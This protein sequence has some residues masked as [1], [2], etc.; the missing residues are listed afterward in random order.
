MIISVNWLKKF[1]DFDMPID[2]LAT[3]I[4][5][6]LVEIESV[7]SL[8]EK[9]K[10]ALVVKVVRAERMV[11]SD[12]LSVVTIDDAQVTNGVERDNQGYVQVVCGAPNI[13]TGQTV[14]WLPPKSIVPNT[15]ATD[16]QFILDVRK[17]R[18]VTSNGMIASA[19]ELDLFDEHE[20]ILVIDDDIKAG[21]LLRDVCELDDYLLDIE[22][23]S[24]THRPDCF[25]IIGFAREV[26]AITGQEFH[27]PDWLAKT[28]PDF[29]GLKSDE[30][31]KIQATIDDPELA[32]RYQAVVVSNADGKRQSPLL[33]QTYL[34][35][36]GLRPINGIVDVTN[37]LMMLTGQPL[38]AFDYDKLVEVGG[39]AD[40]HVR[41][42]HEGEK[43]TL[44]DGKTIT[45][46]EK[47][48]VIAAGDV[49]VGL[50]GAMGGLSTAIDENTR[51]IVIESATF[52]L[53]NLRGTQMRH[54][55]FSE[56]ITRFTKGQSPALT[57]PV[58]ADAVKLMSNWT[59]AQLTSDI[60]EAYPNK[61]NAS[62]INAS[63]AA[64][65]DVLGSN[66]PKDEI[67]KI[68]RNTEF[69]VRAD[70][71]NLVVTAPWWRQDIHIFEDIVEEIGRING[72]DNIKPTL[73]L[74]KFIATRP[75]GFDDFR[76]RIRK[77]MT[78][79][80]ANEVLTYS[81]IHGD[82]LAKVGQ[83]AENSYRIVNSISPSLQYYRQSLTPSLL[84]IVHS[85]IKFGF[86]KFALFEI[87]K[88]HLKSDG[89][90]SESV[91]LESDSM[92]MVVASKMMLKGAPFY[93][94]KKI[95][96]YL[97]Q[98]LGVKLAF[99]PID[100]SLDI[101]AVMVS[102]F[103]HR[104]SAALIDIQ[105]NNVI[106][107]LGEYKRSVAKSFKLPD[108]TAGFEISTRKLYDMV[109]KSETNYQP[110]SRFPSADR[111]ICFRVA[112]SVQYDD[113]INALEKTKDSDSISMSF[114]P[115]DIYRPKDGQTKNVTIRV[116]LTSYDHTLGGNE[117][118]AEINE[119]M[120][121]VSEVTGAEVI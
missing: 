100:K 9:Y 82:L 86:D 5:A 119:L 106:G 26:A 103:E 41:A 92:A 30:T 10:D 98:E 76:A 61:F 117:V 64:I 75:S 11:D 22:N 59:G 111:D 97:T 16:D 54:G 121:R 56:A 47:D 17:L 4:G 14:V 114:M 72:F 21:T 36:V 53:Y 19:R 78:R 110:L 93:Q 102:P 2:D 27:T 113:I 109:C 3:L 45:M 60:A 99:K 7:T 25:G 69:D 84:D 89:Y 85:N 74:R 43:L 20:G 34:A 39:S 88:V 87:N 32:A 15:F 83:E 8:G 1:V 101:D 91:P 55:I 115:V 81:F 107:V 63:V 96:E 31:F 33:I 49:A 52:N 77:I 13:K 29:S 24:L 12:H 62:E 112:D 79:S 35:R 6:R 90:N 70:N 105:T 23:K 42:A 66:L 38:H 80:G 95:L 104:R 116:T 28:Q 57:A 68:L 120:Q 44:L 67:V 50:A 118:S 48:I 73:P 65:N 58:L 46:A 40:I 37:Y 108:Y 18:G 51:N 71:D 94:S